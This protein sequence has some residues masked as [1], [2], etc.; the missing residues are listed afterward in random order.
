MRHRSWAAETPGKYERDYKNASFTFA[1]SKCPVTE[2][3]V[4][5]SLV[6]PT[7]G[8][9]TNFLDIFSNLI[10]DGPFDNNSAMVQAMAW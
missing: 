10:P 3:L 6:T 4:N 8:L 2:K 5:G 7:P 1:K 9:L